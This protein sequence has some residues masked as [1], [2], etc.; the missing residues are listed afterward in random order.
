MHELIE[1]RVP[2]LEET[3]DEAAVVVDELPAQPKM[4]MPLPGWRA[5]LPGSRLCEVNDLRQ[6][7]VAGYRGVVRPRVPWRVLDLHEGL[8]V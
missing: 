3:L 5:N 6:S 7:G 2:N 1:P 8:R 4:F